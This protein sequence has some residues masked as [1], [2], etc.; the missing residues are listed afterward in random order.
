MKSPKKRSVEISMIYFTKFFNIILFIL[1]QPQ[2]HRKV[3]KNFSLFLFSS[4]SSSSYFFMNHLMRITPKYN[5][6]NQEINPVTLLI[7]NPQTPLNLPV[8]PVRPIRG[9][10]SN[11]ES[12]F[13]FSCLMS[14]L[15]FILES[16]SSFSLTFITLM[17]LKMA[18]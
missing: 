3:T 6:Q 9:K 16:F 13:A 8:V 1:K 17:F 18:V 15:S 7:S 14:V 10:C 4:P 11:S 5:R 2:T 12:H